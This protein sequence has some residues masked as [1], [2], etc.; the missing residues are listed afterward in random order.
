MNY[1]MWIL[2]QA[3][4]NLPSGIEGKSLDEIETVTTTSTQDANQI[5]VAKPKP[6]PIMQFCR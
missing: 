6:S 2:A 4:P 5:P 1:N 3:N